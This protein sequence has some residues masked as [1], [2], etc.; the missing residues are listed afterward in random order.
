MAKTREG[1][2][3]RHFSELNKIARP[4]G[5]EQGALDYIAKVGRAAGCE[6]ISDP[7]VGVI[8]RAKATAG[9]ENDPAIIL[10]GHADMVPQNDPD[11]KHEWTKDPI[12]TEEV[13]GWL[14]AKGTTLGA[15]NGIGISAALAVITDKSVSH[16]AIEILA[17]RE[18]ETCMGGANAL[19]AGVL[20]GK[21]LLNL[22]S[23]EEGEIY[24]GCAGGL[25]VDATFKGTKVETADTDI[26]IKVSL[27]GLRGG[28]SGMDINLGRAN[29]NKLMARFLKFAAANYESMLADVQGGNMRNAIPRDATAVLTID[30]EDEEDFME[31]VVEFE[32]M[33]RSEFAETEPGLTFTAEKVETPSTVFYEETTDDLINALQG[34]PCGPLKMSATV[35]GLVETSVNLAMVKTEG[36]EIKVVF[37]IRSS[38]ESE[39]EDVAS[40]IDSIYKLAG[41]S[42]EFN[43]DYPGWK[44][45]T[46]SKAV[47]MVGAAMKEVLGRE[48]KITAVHAGL[49]CGIIGAK[50]EGLDMASFGPTIRHPHSPSEKVN[51][52]TVNRFWEILKRILKG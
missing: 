39:K 35:A 33:F 14:K 6:V 15:D 22:D 27:S 50:Y 26:A 40:T 12:E 36:D 10:Q 48:P 17:T 11:V 4:S 42:V 19:Q 1:E 34:S 41:A 16:P 32:D 46:E 37:L 3:W 45:R 13:D 29:A 24:I 30:S 21:I 23:E 28:H 7:K 25:D 49:E 2:L 9:R 43:G 8:I 31:A 44:P 38:V 47:E 52:E 5:H 20:R 18:E 51:I